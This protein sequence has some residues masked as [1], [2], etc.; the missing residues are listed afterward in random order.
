MKNL[1]SH[2]K[3]S[4]PVAIKIRSSQSL[5][6]KQRRR[7]SSSLSSWLKNLDHLIK[8]QESYTLTDMI[9]APLQA[10]Q[11][12]DTTPSN[13]LTSQDCNPLFKSTARRRL[14]KPRRNAIVIPSLSS[15]QF[16]PSLFEEESLFQESSSHHERETSSSLHEEEYSETDDS[17]N[18][19]LSLQGVTLEDS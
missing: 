11:T 10:F 19:V 1:L 9:D 16:G 4:Q 6:Y 12:E 14:K 18:F 3:S 7:N 17:Q 15:H 8:E 13:N 2:C 5:L